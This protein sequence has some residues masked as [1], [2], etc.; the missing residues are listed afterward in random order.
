MGRVFSLWMCLCRV[1]GNT[2]FFDHRTLLLGL[3]SGWGSGSSLRVLWRFG[4]QSF[5]GRDG[6]PKGKKG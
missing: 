4:W 1:S 3:G 2:Y 5:G 6:I